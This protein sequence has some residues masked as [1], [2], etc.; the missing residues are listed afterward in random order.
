MKEQECYTL[1][2][3]WVITFEGIIKHRFELCTSVFLSFSAKSPTRLTPTEY[4]IHLPKEEY[5][6]PF[7]FH[8][9]HLE[10][11]IFKQKML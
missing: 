10:Q 1:M 3:I 4:D 9:F 5:L 8:P 11:T 7:L 2:Y 6:L